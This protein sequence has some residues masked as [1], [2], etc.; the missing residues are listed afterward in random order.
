M[1]MAATTG[2]RRTPTMP[3]RPTTRVPP[4][5]TMLLRFTLRRL[6][7]TRLQS[8]TR[9]RPTT[10]VRP[11]RPICLRATTRLQATTHRPPSVFRTPNDMTGGEEAIS[12]RLIP[13]GREHPCPLLSLAQEAIFPSLP[14]TARGSTNLP[15]PTTGHRGSPLPRAASGGEGTMPRPP[16]TAGGR[17]MSP[18]H[19]S[20]RPETPGGGG[21]GSQPR[22]LVL[23]R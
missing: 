10:R 8:T 13:I 5:R 3:L 23:A 6:P 12:L 18:L 4:T 1:V 7:T 22:V 15:C 20:A 19:I 9:L 2:R 11:S 17:T 14:R 21:S 16:T